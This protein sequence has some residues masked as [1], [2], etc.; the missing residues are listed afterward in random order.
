MK[1]ARVKR[2]CQTC[3]KEFSILLSRLKYGAC[4]YC[5]LKC[6]GV[7]RHRRVTKT[8]IQC[9]QSFEVKASHADQFCCGKACVDKFKITK[10][11]RICKTC[12]RKFTSIPSRVGNYCSHACACISIVPRQFVHISDTSL[13]K[14][15]RAEL[16]R[17]GLFFESNKRMGRYVVDFI[18]PLHQT[19]IEVDGE[20]WHQSDE[21]IKKDW[22]RDIWFLDQ[23][24]DVLRFP[25][26][27]LLNHP[28]TCFSRLP[29][30]KG[31]RRR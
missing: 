13:E 25:E 12:G 29:E 24:Y 14:L 18:L 2:A 19:I 1:A 27:L 10:I 30:R 16:Q 3:G 4:I 9:G 17:R 28:E 26:R 31:G 6:A 8:C 22:N 23:G 21:N 20:Y 15:V 5:S 7:A 11:F